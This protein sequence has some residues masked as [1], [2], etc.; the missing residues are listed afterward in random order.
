MD[1]K[2]RDSLEADE[3]ESYLNDESTK[4]SSLQRLPTIKKIFM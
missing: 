2:K 1:T 3:V 4:L